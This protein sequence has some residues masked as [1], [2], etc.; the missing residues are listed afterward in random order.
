MANN[1]DLDPKSRLGQLEKLQSRF[2]SGYL[3]NLNTYHCF[4]NNPIF[5]NQKEQKYKVFF[6]YSKADRQTLQLSVHAKGNNLYPS[7]HKVL[8]AKKECIPNSIVSDYQAQVELQDLMDH[9]AKRLM[10]VCEMP[11]GAE[12]QLLSKVGFDG[13]S[14]QSVYKQAC[15]D[16]ERNL[17]IEENLFLT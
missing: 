7:Y 13:S 4:S 5:E 6:Y 3:K 11:D 10:K 12:L 2:S 15:G 14:G 1:V 17:K 16:E 9:T 8:A